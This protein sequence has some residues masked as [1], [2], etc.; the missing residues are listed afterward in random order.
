M[1]LSKDLGSKYFAAFIDIN[2]HLL[3]NEIHNL[4]MVT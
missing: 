2:G 3:Y 1:R 4:I